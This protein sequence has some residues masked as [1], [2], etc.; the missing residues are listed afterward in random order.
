[1][2]IQFIAS[3]LRWFL[4]FACYV[5]SHSQL[6]SLTQNQVNL[7]LNVKNS[8]QNPLSQI[9]LQKNNREIIVKKETTSQDGRKIC[10]SERANVAKNRES[11]NH[12][13]AQYQVY[14]PSYFEE[15]VS[16]ELLQS[17]LVF[18]KETHIMDPCDSVQSVSCDFGPTFSWFT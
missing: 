5:K 13:A 10:C 18:T 3:R 12:I 8:S 14:T 17:R 4:R 7:I 1:M 9:Q 6:P 2:W 16:R 11:S 15:G